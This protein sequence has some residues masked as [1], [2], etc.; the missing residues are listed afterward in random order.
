MSGGPD[1]DRRWLRAA[2][3]LSRLSPPS[4]THYAVGAIVVDEYGEA[5]ASGYTGET[6]PHHHAEE[7]ALTKLAGRDDLDLSRATVYTSMEPCTVRR[8]RPVPCTSLL[9]AAGI[10]RV[11]LALREPLLFAD[12]DGVQTLRTGGVDVVEIGDLG[13]LVVEINAHVLGPPD[14]PWDSR[15]K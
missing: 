15:W 2:I 1:Q 12:C 14:D 3:E 8:S 9:L 6:D 10:T 11:V 13:H 4:P 5:L 7:A